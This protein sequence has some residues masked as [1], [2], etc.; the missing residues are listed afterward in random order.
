MGPCAPLGLTAVR[1]THTH[2]HECLKRTLPEEREAY[3]DFKLQ[4]TN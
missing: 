2:T 3:H 4:I 1:L